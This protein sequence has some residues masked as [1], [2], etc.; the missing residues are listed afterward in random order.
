[1]FLYDLLDSS[2]TR[3][4]IRGIRKVKTGAVRQTGMP[5][6][7]G[8][9]RGIETTIEFDEE[10]YVGQWMFCLRV[11]WKRFWLYASVN[12]FNQLVAVTSQKEG[13][14]KRWPTE[15]RRTDPPLAQS[16]LTS[17]IA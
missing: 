8:F 13:I 17:R 14:L 5:S 16:C 10:Q 1:L 9:V 11:C 4:Q 15:S 6:A 2:A 7:A 3:K 12:S